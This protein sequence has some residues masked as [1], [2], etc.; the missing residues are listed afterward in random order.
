MRSWRYCSPFHLMTEQNA[1]LKDGREGWLSSIHPEHLS[2]YILGKMDSANTPTRLAETSGKIPL[3]LKTCDAQQRQQV[4]VFI[5]SWLQWRNW[6]ASNS[7]MLNSSL[8]IPDI[9]CQAMEGWWWWGDSEPWENKMLNTY[10]TLITYLKESEKNNK[11]SEIIGLG[12]SRFHPNLTFI[13]GFFFSPIEGYLLELTR[14]LYI[15]QD[16]YSK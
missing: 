4:H 1:S 7:W 5:V 14:S 15:Y 2:L 10:Y 12:V 3:L 13:V 9:I 16:L 8:L 11:N 6:V